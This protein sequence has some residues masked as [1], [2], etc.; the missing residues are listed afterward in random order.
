[1]MY[2]NQ[3]LLIHS[4]ADKSLTKQRVNG[5]AC[6]ISFVTL[7][8]DYR[9]LIIVGYVTNFWLGRYNIYLMDL[10]S[11]KWQF[12]RCGMDILQ[13]LASGMMQSFHG[14]LTDISGNWAYP[15]TRLHVSFRRQYTMSL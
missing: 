7:T 11:S 9:C 2:D 1:M 10:K 6:E 14:L 15:A 13:Y 3:N 8:A 5:I 4:I 12:R